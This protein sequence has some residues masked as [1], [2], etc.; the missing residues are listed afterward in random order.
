MPRI[1]PGSSS[2]RKDDG[3]PIRSPDERNLLQ[4]SPFIG[5]EEGALSPHGRFCRVMTN[6]SGSN[7]PPTFRA[8]HSNELSQAGSMDSRDDEY[9]NEDATEENDDIKETES[10]GPECAGDSH[11][12]SPSTPFAVRKK[13]TWRGI[14]TNMPQSRSSN[15][16]YG[17]RKKVLGRSIGE[18]K[19]RLEP[20]RS[21][22]LD[23][24][25]AS[26]SRLNSDSISRKKSSRTNE[27]LG[28]QSRQKE[29]NSSEA[30]SV[31]VG[32]Q[33]NSDIEDLLTSDKRLAPIEQKRA[34][35]AEVDDEAV[36]EK[37][38]TRITKMFPRAPS[39]ERFE[40][41]TPTVEENDN[42]NASTMASLMRRLNPGSTL[43]AKAASHVP[44][45][46]DNDLRRNVSSKS[47]LRPRSRPLR[48]SR[49][50]DAELES[51]EAV[52]GPAGNVTLSNEDVELRRRLLGR[53]A[54]SSNG[55][56]L[57]SGELASNALVPRRNSLRG[58]IHRKSGR[59]RMSPILPNR[60][61]EKLV[62]PRSG[63][64][65]VRPSPL[66]DGETVFE[67][68]AWKG[69]ASPL[70]RYSTGRGGKKGQV[71]EAGQSRPPE[72]VSPESSAVGTKCTRSLGGN[73]AV[74]PPISD[75]D[76][77]RRS[78]EIERFLNDMA[79]L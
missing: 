16:T 37:M 18:T 24:E 9:K 14:D 40:G 64:L 57:P 31:G 63:S 56:A 20:L 60:T 5:L 27:S 55:E 41:K 11:P 43:R 6:K 72:K 25:S 77:T 50:L 65:S 38:T 36:F 69:M 61:A 48:M 1:P 17:M 22:D 71:E 42:S 74:E 75:E 44:D 46:E 7:A 23:R 28:P 51:P 32:E 73:N 68:K 13:K 30:R 79:D 76:F 54:R 19:P 70:Q 34:N 62:S 59:Q 15:D 3:K 53:P 35:V 21:P 2:G 39:R 29:Q 45:E 10:T 49:S 78:V 67:M 58:L 52:R 47:C 33:E 12:E 4:F 66:S 8:V 26:E